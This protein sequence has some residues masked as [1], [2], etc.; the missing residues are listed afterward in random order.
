[1]QYRTKAQATK[2]FNKGEFDLLFKDVHRYG[3]I[4]ADKEWEDDRG[5]LRMMA[6]NWHG[7]GW[8]YTRLNG[9]GIEWGMA[10]APYIVGIHGWV[11]TEEEN[12]R[13]KR[14]AAFQV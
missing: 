4:V 1:M 12:E 2:A 11:V 6:F 9:E 5:C 13:H 10:E 14:I 3:T 8:K 7:K